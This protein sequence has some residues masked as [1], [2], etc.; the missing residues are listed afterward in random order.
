MKVSIWSYTGESENTIMVHQNEVHCCV[1]SDKNEFL[2]FLENA[3][4]S[5]KSIDLEELPLCSPHYIDDKNSYIKDPCIS[6]KRLSLKFSPLDENII[7][8][9]IRDYDVEIEFGQ[10]SLSELQSSFENTSKIYPSIFANKISIKLDN[11]VNEIGSKLII[12]KCFKG[13]PIF[14]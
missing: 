7:N 11:G 12:W 10:N 8:F 3:K 1:L 9:S 2:N 5:D 4:T 13:K 14:A 6:F